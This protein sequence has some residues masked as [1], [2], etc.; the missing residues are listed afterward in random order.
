MC[1]TNQNCTGL[2]SV[3][4]YAKKV[5]RIECYTFYGVYKATLYVPEESIEAY[6]A[7]YY[8]QD[9]GTVLPIDDIENGIR[10][11]SINSTNKNKIVKILC[12]KQVLIKKGNKTYTI[13]GSAVK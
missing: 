13:A 2:T 8:W 11:D 6:K 3:Y 5:P 1:A 7:D 9:F 12:K 4:C 10:I